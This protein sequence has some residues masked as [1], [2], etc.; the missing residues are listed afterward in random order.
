MKKYLIVFGACFFCFISAADAQVGI[1]IGPR[2]GY[3]PGY[4]GMHRRYARQNRNLPPFQPSVNVSFGYGF[5]NLDKDA[6]PDFYNQ[7]KGNASSQTGPVTGAI[8]YR[9]SRAMSMGI[10]VTHGDVKV[11][12]YNYNGSSAPAFTGSLDN[13]CFMFDLVNYIPAGE[14][15][16][17][18]I[19][20]AIGI[21]TWTQSFTDSS[22]GKLNL[23]GNP[24][25]LAYQVG[26]GADFY[27][28]K[29]A[30]IFVEGGYGKYIVHG[31]I[32]FKF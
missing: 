3:G 15:V 7:Y 24:S 8:D 19:R 32:S 12:Y 11:P 4:R 2:F 25:E 22:G 21:N 26:I 30:A 6:L 23:A 18:Y 14:R 1:F 10:M 5:P 9:F 29:N 16:T 17:P 20:T 13:W 27:L 31:G 28:S